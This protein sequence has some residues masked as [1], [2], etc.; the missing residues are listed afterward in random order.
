V[1]VEGDVAGD[2]PVDLDDPCG[3]GMVGDKIAKLAGEVRRVAVD[4]LDGLR[5]PLERVEVVVGSGPDEH[6]A[7]A[8]TGMLDRP[9][10]FRSEAGTY[11]VKNLR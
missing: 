8:V 7:K 4:P 2:I 5:H 3:D 11:G 6:G 10:N 9:T 1:P